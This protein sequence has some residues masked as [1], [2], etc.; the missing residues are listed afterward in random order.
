MENQ[1]SGH[2]IG[3]KQVVPSGEP[4]IEV[5]SSLSG[6]AIGKVPEAGASTVSL[7]VEMANEAF[8]KWSAVPVKERVQ[9]L[10]RFKSLLEKNINEL[11]ELI[12]LENG[13][14]FGEAKAEIDKGIEVL[15][16][17]CSFPQIMD[18]ERLE[19]SAGVDCESRRLPL[20]IGRAHV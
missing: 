7:A 14:T 15:E 17:A 12:R 9:V 2:Y 13:K 16:F 8:I 1:I 10:F 18:Q 4:L 6:A 5:T 19:V 3:G 11:S 20:E